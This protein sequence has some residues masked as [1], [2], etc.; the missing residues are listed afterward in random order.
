[1]TVFEKMLSMER[2][3]EFLNRKECS[4]NIS[5]DELSE[6]NDYIMSSECTQD[7]QRLMKGDF[8]FDI[9]TA[10]LLRKG[11]SNKRRI[12]YRFKDHERMLM[13]YMAH[14]MHDFDYLYSD[15]L[16]SFRIGKHISDI[17]SE[18]TALGCAENGWVLKGDI[19]GFGDHVDPEI[20]CAQLAEIYEKDDPQLLAFFRQ[21]LLRG[22]F[23]LKGEHKHSSTGALSGC[24][25]TNFF[26]NVYLL[27][28]DEMVRGE[29]DYYCRFA[30]DIAIFVKSEEAAEEMMNK[31][32]LIFSERGLTFN[33]SKTEIVPPGGR[34][35]LLGFAIEG[36]QYDIAD[37]SI[38]KI[39]WKLRHRAKKLV[40]M[41]RK[42]Y[43]SKEEAEM[44]MIKRID[45]YFFK[46]D[47]E[48][49]EL[50]WVDWAF[51]VLTRS[52]S[53]KQLDSIS[54]SCIRYV[55]SCGRNTASKYKI[56][57]KDMR[58]KGYR[59]LVNTYYHREKLER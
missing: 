44:R 42:G 53:L 19:T 27:D 2:R 4:Y 12:V 38:D 40:R 58:K 32:R 52:D 18:I 36:R 30:D 41:Q 7:I 48:K 55:G 8:Y 13:K 23:Y 15:S 10:I 57:Y 54:Q 31:L 35:E 6:L 47:V 29:S 33:E 22:E 14:I 50:N 16:Y 39:E 43:I 25:L 56:R 51:R 1:M 28:V 34:F 45:D 46:R 9:P 11:H 3:E 59:T 37:S 20:L 49:H 21:L 26:E 24:A 17:F 5:E